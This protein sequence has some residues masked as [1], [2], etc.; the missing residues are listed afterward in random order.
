M[1]RAPSGARFFCPEDFAEPE[2]GKILN[3]EPIPNPR[4]VLQL[5]ARRSARPGTLLKCKR[6]KAMAIFRGMEAL[7]IDLAFHYSLSAPASK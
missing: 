5:P 3:D 2:S 4:T 1:L 6:T 7:C